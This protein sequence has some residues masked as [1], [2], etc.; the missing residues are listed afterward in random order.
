MA[1]AAGYAVLARGR[2]DWTWTRW[3][4]FGTGLGILWLALETPLD[5]IGDRYSQSAH[6]LQHVLIGVAAPPLLLLGL[7][8]SMAAA[9]TRRLGWLR[10]GLEP[11]PAQVA[12]AVVMI[13][14]H[15][16]GAYNLTLGNEGV[17]IFEH[18]TFIAAGLLFW[19]PM[20]A[21]TA[22]TLSWQMGWGAKFVYLLVGT[23]P[24]D[25]VALVLQFSR[26]VFY[27]HYAQAYPLI[28]GWTP[29][30]DQNVSG[31]ILMVFGKTSY[32]VAALTL[33]FRWFGADRYRPGEE[34]LPSGWPAAGSGVG[35]PPARAPRP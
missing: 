12:A 8:R 35:P 22:A 2:A 16:P 31:V 7:T 24:Q 14:W 33:F 34:D 26:E 3:V 20:L 28:R 21:A 5:S 13:A 17:H 9:I 18:L 10:H 25:S 11:V 23:M 15:I 1:L 19:W 4:Y 27:P 6:M 30:I 32:A 29:V